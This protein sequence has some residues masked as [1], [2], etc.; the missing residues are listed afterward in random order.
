[1]TNPP[2]DPVDLREPDQEYVLTEPLDPDMAGVFRHLPSD[3]RTQRDRA[4]AFIQAEVLPVIDDYWER[5]EY[6]LGLLRRLGELDLLRDGVDVPG[7][8]AVSPLAAG[9]I[10]LEL[11]RGDGSVGTMTAV[12]GGLAMRSIALLGSSQQRAEW[13][14]PLARGR[15]IGAFGLTEPDH[16]SDTVALGTTARAVNGGFVLR[17]RKT[18]IGSGSVGDVTIVWAR[19]DDGAV[20]GYLVPQNAA[21]YR[22]QVITGKLSLRA[23]HQ[24]QI[25]L[26]DV[27]L[28][29][30]ALLPGSLTFKDTSRVLRATR[31]SVG[32]AALGHAT[33]CYES[34]VHYSRQR[35]QFGRPLAASQIVQ[36]RLA[37]MLSELTQVQTLLVALTQRESDG[38]LDGP[39]ASMGKYT[40]TRTARSIAANAQDLLGGNGILLKHRVAR[41]FAD[42]EGLHTYEGTETIQALLIGRSITGISAFTT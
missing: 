6:P 27:Q 16:G 31:L 11:N 22:A 37:R 23:I 2:S 34:A 14:E 19:G 41:H 39:Q 18:W 35:Y 40:A 10:N 32:W 5:A 30:D 1:M 29:P 42:V 13:L 17:G 38:V 21:G 20:H 15:R 36:E 33:A 28:A 9:L 12:Q 4:R 25:T 3:D 8:P 24:A 26:D 7:F